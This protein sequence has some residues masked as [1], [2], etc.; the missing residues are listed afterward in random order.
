MDLRRDREASEGAVQT[1][2]S[3]GKDHREPT[4]RKRTGY[5]NYCVEKNAQRSAQY[6]RDTAPGPVLRRMSEPFTQCVG[7]G[8]RWV[9]NMGAMNEVTVERAEEVIGTNLSAA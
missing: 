1:R 6:K 9:E 4:K 3:D 7:L 2:G 5:E 8:S